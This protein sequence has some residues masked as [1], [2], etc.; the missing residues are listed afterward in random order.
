MEKTLRVNTK[1]IKVKNSDGTITSTFDRS[2][3]FP[4]PEIFQHETIESLVKALGADYCLHTLTTG[5]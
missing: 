5:S 3:D 2:V 1:E 4:T